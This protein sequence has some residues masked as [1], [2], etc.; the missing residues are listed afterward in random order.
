MTAVEILEEQIIRFHNWKLN[1]IYDENCFDEIELDKSIKQAKEMERQE[2]EKV[3]PLIDF[4]KDCATNWDC[5]TDS[6]RYK[7]PCRM[8]EATK[9]LETYNKTTP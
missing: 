5:D 2:Q 7:T 6:H 9:I 3:K 4:A 8:C 1:P